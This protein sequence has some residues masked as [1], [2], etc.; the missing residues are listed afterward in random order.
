MLI[1][2]FKK[3]LAEVIDFVREDFTWKKYAYAAGLIVLLDLLQINFDFYNAVTAHWVNDGIAWLA[4]PALYIIIYYAM[5]VPT[6]LLSGEGWRLRQWQVWVWPAALAVL[7]GVSQ[8]S[9][10]YEA[11][12]NKAHLTM[13]EIYFVSSSLVF[14]TRGCVVLLGIC[15]FRYITERRFALPGLQR[16]ASYINVYLTVFMIM[17]PALVVFAGTP[18]FLSYYP[19]F[20]YWLAT[21]AF[22]MED[23][24]HIAIFDV[25]YGID[26]LS[27]ETLYRG[28]FVLGM[29]RWL[30][31]RC[32]LPMVA[33]YVS[34]HM[35]KPAVEMCTAAIGGYL[36]GI[37]AYRTKHLWGGVIVHVA[38]A[39]SIEVL[40]TMWH[41]S[42]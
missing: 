28:A 39:L 12:C 16:N 10:P 9:I 11:L 19:R 22:G 13:Y 8:Y 20:K 34:V 23:W 38:I 29:L 6:V 5:L 21:G 37:L 2:D 7:Q 3:L 18:D 40:T 26:F 41:L 36:L 35:G 30:G 25:S 1:K 31:P 17:F 15:T 4:L 24:Q 14:F 42:L 33:L 32:V 27:V